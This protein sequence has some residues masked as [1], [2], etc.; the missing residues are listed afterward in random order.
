MDASVLNFYD[1]LAEDYDLLF[2]NWRESVISQGKIL[3]TVITQELRKKTVSILD[4]SCGIGTQAI[5][6]ANC[7]HTMAA[8]DLSPLAIERA[9]KEAKMLGVSIDFKVDDFCKMENVK[10]CF[11]AA[12]SCDNAVPHLL[13]DDDLHL[14]LANMWRVLN[15]GGLL[16]L[17]IR[18]Y[19]QIRKNRPK[20]T[21]PRFLD[22]NRITF[23]IWEWE[24]AGNVYEVNQFI[25][26]C[27]EG[28]WLTTCA[29]TKYRALLRHELTTSLAKAGFSGVKWLM[30]E[31]SEYYQPIVLARKFL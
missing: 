16:L 8:F 1:T 28:Q 5:G 22:G 30:P 19:D 26:K 11:D 20:A 27:I 13:H 23:Q 31:Q 12:L 2:I 29:K 21:E 18:D 4:C 17:S 14:M 24:K 15:P 10:D 7:G 6:L 9:K 3:D 25:M